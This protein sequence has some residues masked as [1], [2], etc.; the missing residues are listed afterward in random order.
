VAR[1]LHRPDVAGVGETT[2]ADLRRGLGL[3]ADGNP[4]GGG[5]IAFLG[6]RRL[7]EIEPRDL[8]AYAVHV[9]K[10]GGRRGRPVARDTIRLAL[11]PVKALPATAAEDGLIR[12]NPAAGLRNL[13]PPVADGE[14]VDDKVRALTEAEL[15]A[16]LAELPGAS[17][18]FFEFLAQTGLRI[19]EAVE[20]RWGDVDLG[21]GWLHVRRRF[22]KGRVGL[23]KGRK[24]RRVRLAAGVSRSLW[25]LRKATRAADGDLVFT[26][27]DGGR[28]DQSNLMTRVLKPAA[29]RAG[30]GEMV[31]TRRSERAETWVGFHTFRHT[32]ATIRFR[33][34]WNAAQVQRF[35]GHSDPGFTLRRYIHLLDDDLPE[36]DFLHDLGGGK[37]GQRVAR[38]PSEIERDQGRAKVA[39]SA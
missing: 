4:T 30:L 20:L 15:A 34:G 14:Q 7:A 29:V 9:A 13:L 8:R 39:E 26:N 22:Y 3:D 32:C 23:P 27:T 36:P 31:K 17:R 6:G 12:S 38:R 24:T 11:A 21:E 18:P 16:L 19:G 33:R 28:L 1:D 5:A 35:L 10:R 37:G 2:L 25:T